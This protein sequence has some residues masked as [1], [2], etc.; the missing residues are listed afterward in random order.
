MAYEFEH[1]GVALEDDVAFATIAN[2][3]VNVITIPVFTDLLHFAQQVAADDDVRVVV[4]RSD[5]PD[6]F[7][8]HFDVEAIMGFPADSP[9]ERGKSVDENGFHVL[10]ELFRTMPKATIA[11]I[12]A[13]VGGGGSEL[14]SSCDMRFGA[15]G[16]TVISQPEVAIG[17]LPGGSGTQR[18]PRLIGRGRALEVILGCDDLD[19]ETAERW[20]YLNRA[21]APDELR[22]Y[23]TRLARRIASFPPRAVADAKAATLRAEP[24]WD[25][26]LIEEAYLFQGLL[27]TPEAQQRMRTFMERGGQTR[28]VELRIADLCL[29]VADG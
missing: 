6:F 14:A 8:A 22:P 19:A 25:E 29:E 26:G 16:K 11:E 3:P 1:L 18:L 17:I 15:L 21:L 10:C 27:R 28:E 4:L 24:S 20:G 13:R 23:V 12:N 5:D 7:I 9:A 2:P